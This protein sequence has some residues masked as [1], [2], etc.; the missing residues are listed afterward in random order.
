M[1]NFLNSIRNPKVSILFCC[2]ASV[3]ILRFML[4]VFI[5]LAIDED[6]EL[7]NPLGTRM[8]EFPVS[9]MLSKMLLMSGNASCKPFKLLS[10]ILNVFEVRKSAFLST[11]VELFLIH[12]LVLCYF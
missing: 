1:L 7:T 9:P 12:A 4:F 6:S 2:H 11:E 3:M 10:I 8:A 5:F